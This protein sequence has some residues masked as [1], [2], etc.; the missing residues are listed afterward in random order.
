MS[1]RLDGFQNAVLGHGMRNK[2]PAAHFSFGNR[3]ILTD[4]LLG[5]MYLGSALTR[6]I[7]RLPA[8]EAVK[9]WIE[10]EGDEEELALQ[11][12][13]DL[14]SEEHFANAVSWARLYGGAVI[15]LLAND[16]GTLEDPLDENRIRQV[17]SL[18]VYDR[19]QVT[20]NEAVLYED[21]TNKQYGQPQY[22]QVNPIGGVP[23]LV[24]ESRL[25]RFVGDPLPDFYRLQYQNWGLPVLQGMWD[26]LYQNGHSQSLAIKIMERMSQ[27]ILKL[28]GM[29]DVLTQE[30]GDEEVQK[31]LQMIDMGRSILNTIAIDGKD[32]FDIK[33]MSL[34][35][36]PELLD[37]FGQT[38]AAAA[39]IPFTLLFGR[40]PAG[41]NATGQSDLENFYNSVRRLQKRQIKP[42]LDKLVRLIMLSKDGPFHSCQPEAWCIEFNALWLPSE[43]ER[44][45]TEKL[46]ADAA[47]ARADAANVYVGAGALDPAELRKKLA[48][49]GEYDIDTSLVP[50]EPTEEEMT[51]EP[52]TTA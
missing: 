30:G 48:D 27:G 36:I 4:H 31:R 51:D 33:N 47:K 24:H 8:E 29:L 41:M 1:L 18:R 40:S 32:D 49:D 46:E 5:Q 16:G 39:N 52:P 26:E 3:P 7:I 19:T 34:T 45:E 10:V 21:P 22:Y 9:N 15:L 23:Y 28:D 50:I 43:K 11:S 35:Q 14:G 2:D 17:E 25:L 13:D 37:R 12:L 6:K 38:L 42:N 44:A 20:W